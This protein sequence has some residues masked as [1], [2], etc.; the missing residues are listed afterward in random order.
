MNRIC[1]SIQIILWECRLT[2]GTYNVAKVVWEYTCT[3]TRLCRF[4]TAKYFSVVYVKWKR[5]ISISI[6]NEYDFTPM[7]SINLDL[8]SVFVACKMP[9]RFYCRHRTHSTTNDLPLL[10][11]FIL[12][13]QRLVPRTQQL[14]T[15]F[16]AFSSISGPFFCCLLKEKKCFTFTHFYLIKNLLEIDES[17]FLSWTKCVVCQVSRG[18]QKKPTNTTKAYENQNYLDFFLIIWNDCSRKKCSQSNVFLL[19]SLT[20]F[21]LSCSFRTSFEYFRH[22]KKRSKDTRKSRRKE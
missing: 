1:I 9:R 7:R 22:E 16:F 6:R 8:P 11:T 19:E 20:G 3:C 10:Y 17:K 13:A 2:G 5:H 15:I 21:D 4:S 14:T 18:N 12:S